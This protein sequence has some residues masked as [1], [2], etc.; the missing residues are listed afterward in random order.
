MLLPTPEVV[1]A[2]YV[3][4]KCKIHTPARD[5]AS[6]DSMQKQSKYAMRKKT[7]CEGDALASGH[8]K[9]IVRSKNQIGLYG[10]YTKNGGRIQNFFSGHS[11][12]YVDYSQALRLV[13]KMGFDTQTG[14][15]IVVSD[16]TLR[17]FEVKP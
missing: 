6:N 13:S 2:I 3:Q 17:N 8:Y 7:M 11:L 9:S 14:K 10:W 16:E 5:P 12:D 4:A 1:D 15:Y